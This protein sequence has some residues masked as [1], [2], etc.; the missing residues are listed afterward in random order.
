TLSAEGTGREC[1]D[2]V[3]QRL[4][5]QEVLLFGLWYRTR[6]RQMRWAEM[7]KPLKK[8]LEKH[9]CESVVNFG[10][11]FCVPSCALPQQEA[12][13]YQYYL[14]L[15]KAVVEGQ[16]LCTF[17]QGVRLAALSV[18]ANFGD[19]D[20]R[21]SQDFLRDYVLFPLAWSQDDRIVEELTQKVAAFHQKHRGMRPAEA[22]LLYIQEA[23]KLE[24][25]GEESF[26]AKDTSGSDVLL[27][28][29]YNG[30]FVRHRN[31]KP[32]VTFSS[33]RRWSNIS[34]VSHSK[35]ALVIELTGRVESLH[36][37]LEDIETAKYLSRVIEARHKFYTLNKNL[38]I[39]SHFAPPI[40]RCVLWRH[41]VLIKQVQS[42]P[43]V[44]APL[45]IP[46]GNRYPEPHLASQDNIFYPNEDG[47][48][49]RSQT[50]LDH[51]H[52]NGGGGG[53]GGGRL[54]N[55]SVY[56]APSVNSLNHFAQASPMSSDLS[57]PGSEAAAGVLARPPEPLQQ[58]HSALV[59]PSY[60]PTPDY[61]TVMR[62]AGRFGMPC[63]ADGNVGLGE[64]YAY[65]RAAT[66]AYSQPEIRQGQYE[67]RPPY[68]Y[69]G[70]GAPSQL[71]ATQSVIGNAEIFHA[72]STPE[73]A[74]DPSQYPPQVA[75]MLRNH[76]SRPPPPYP[77]PRPAASTPDLISHQRS[78]AGAASANGGYHQHQHH[79]E[80]MFAEPIV[81]PVYRQNTVP[82]LSTGG[83]GAA[84]VRKR[85]SLEVNSSVVRD[86]EALSLRDRA[87]SSLAIGTSSPYQHQQQQQQQQLPAHY[88]N[89]QAL[90]V[91][92]GEHTDGLQPP[93]RPP[94]ELPAQSYQHNL[95][96]SPQLQAMLARLPNKPPPEYPRREATL[97][98]PPPPL[99]MMSGGR[100]PGHHPYSNGVSDGSGV[101]GDGRLFAGSAMV[102][103]VSEPDLS[104]AVKTRTRANPAR[105]RPVSE[106]F[107]VQDSIVEREFVLRNME[108]RGSGP[109]E[110]SKLGPI[111]L[112][113]LNGL[114]ISQLPVP[115]E[116]REE[117]ARGQL[118]ERCARLEKRVARGLVSAEYECIPRTRPDP[119]Y[120]TAEL[121]DNQERNRFGD[122][123]PYEQTRVEL[124]PSKDNPTGYINA[125]HVRVRV[126][127][128][129]W[130]YIATQGPLP[131]TCQDFWQMIWE[132]G[133]S[134]IAMVTP[135]QESGRQKCH[136]YWP[137]LGSKRNSANYGDYRVTTKFRTDSGSYA[138]TGLKV[139]H[140]PSGQERTAWH[141]HYPDW[142]DHGCPEDV[143]RF[144]AFLEEVQSVRR[145]TNSMLPPHTASPPVVVHCSAGVGRSGVLI[146]TEITIAGLEHNV[147]LDVPQALGV[148]RGQRMLMVQTLAQYQFVYQALIQFLNNSRLI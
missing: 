136:R 8:Q 38:T 21:E 118:D 27:G 121:P 126:G 47:Y 16:L 115:E 71:C 73:L 54:P 43:I 105:E 70:P 100:S 61:D 18:Q 36:Y 89:G 35:S 52:V 116:S 22:E 11:M 117:T 66:L 104:T 96:Y 112:A 41:S 122:V 109:A 138:T 140:L 94:F 1:L 80:R 55:G 135:E 76:F 125:S 120:S 26:S 141:L 32:P 110:I 40:P 99:P 3:A 148:L 6:H 9:G 69:L 85:Y 68:F 93:P 143:Q 62:Q 53:G 42:H 98:P 103:S 88:Y 114:S 77:T 95:A 2:P 131:N 119:V 39:A 72:V 129:Q 84:G 91:G 137:K 25:Y 10:V 132:Q 86:M 45:Q 15:K 50:S 64:A 113:A 107:A 63:R 56:S 58:R 139:K 30:V 101:G 46:Y 19:H 7:E 4:E 34:H 87:V 59:M 48:Y 29:S 12:T 111:K 82:Q 60:R 124:L 33:T 49:Y 28:T 108:K 130:H 17:E 37:Q 146:L 65:G 147:Q 13:R 92:N 123:L 142:P 144:L 90:L 74:V 128:E 79:R 127:G 44:P 134:V 106:L 24:G 31:E 57:I 145:H 78:F 81:H 51:V 67:Q 23:E 83:R 102:P 133:V 5:L 75:A 97:P 14:Q 20:Q